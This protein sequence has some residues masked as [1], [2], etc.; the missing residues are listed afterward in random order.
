VKDFDNLFTCFFWIHTKLLSESFYCV[1]ARGYLMDKLNEAPL[2]IFIH[3]QLILR[4]LQ[5]VSR[6]ASGS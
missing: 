2:K 6:I 5:I 3:K 4:N 1:P